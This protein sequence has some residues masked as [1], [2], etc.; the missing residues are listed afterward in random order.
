ME[1]TECSETLAYNIQTPG[2][3]PEEST[4]HSEQGESLKSE[5]STLIFPF[6]YHPLLIA[7]ETNGVIFTRLET[8]L[9]L[10]SK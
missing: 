9:L 5:R 8:V 4:Q 2:N 1:H 10:L 7:H 6:V 3:Y